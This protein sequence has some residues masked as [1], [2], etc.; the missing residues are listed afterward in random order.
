MPH[1]AGGEVGAS[2][3]WRLVM[4]IS[5][6]EPVNAS[7]DATARATTVFSGLT[8]ADDCQFGSMAN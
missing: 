6:D 4:A 7:G 5:S 2:T 1:T 3:G 8:A